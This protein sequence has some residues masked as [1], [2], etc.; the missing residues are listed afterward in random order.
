MHNHEGCEERAAMD[1]RFGLWLKT[2]LLHLHEVS[3]ILW[4]IHN[5]K[6]RKDDL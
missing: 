5:G 3:I 2:S 6:L 1:L 4:T